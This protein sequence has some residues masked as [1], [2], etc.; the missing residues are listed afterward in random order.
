MVWVFR[1]HELMEPKLDHRE[2]EGVDVLE[3]VLDPVILCVAVRREKL[4]SG[5]PGYFADFNSAN[6]FVLLGHGDQGL[7]LDRRLNCGRGIIGCEA[8]CEWLTIISWLCLVKLPLN[9][10][11][12][13]NR[14]KALC[15][16]A[17]TIG[18]SSHGNHTS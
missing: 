6:S 18:P 7:N 8:S 15:S 3:L 11:L 16:H 2:D 1:T 13:G 4:L 5:L 14:A 9:Q 17:T 12:S 10:G